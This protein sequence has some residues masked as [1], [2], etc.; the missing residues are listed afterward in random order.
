MNHHAIPLRT[1]GKLSRSNVVRKERA[2]R[3]CGCTQNRACEDD[4]MIDACCWVEADL[5]SA[6]LSGP[7][8]MRFM[9]GHK[10]PSV[11]LDPD[12]KEAA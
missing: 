3:R 4:R 11:G 9:A 6:C 1:V 10:R 8:F 12:S 7:E 5:C 2:C